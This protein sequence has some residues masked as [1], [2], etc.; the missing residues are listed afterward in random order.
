MQLYDRDYRS[1]L[2]AEHQEWQALQES[3]VVQRIAGAEIRRSRFREYPKAARHF[4]RLFPNNYLD[5][6]E[7]N[8]KE[9]L[10]ERIRGFTALL[11]SESVSERQV[12]NFIIE[13]RA[14]FI[15]G[16]L[17]HAY[18]P[19]G[20]HEAY[21]FPEFQLGN[22]FKVDHLLV[23]KNSGGW[24][25]VFVE[26][27]APTGKITLVDG[28]LGETF[29]KGLAQVGEWD[30]W[31]DARYSSISESFEKATRAGTVLPTE[32]CQ[33]DRSRIHFVVVAG[34]RKDFREA[35]YRI[36]RKQPQHLL[37]YD[38]V[39]DAARYVIGELTY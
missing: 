23:G 38:N 16:A 13:Q 11:D 35:T 15:V 31:L 27:E 8:E 20:H 1:L 17:L 28:S 5:T 21:L 10:S 22:S 24:H 29:R 37:H 33:L 26:L 18:F 25:F 7:L 12:L 39:V 9:V 2:P 34:R 4:T 36:C 19:F 6:V 30:A 14:Y 32:F 3:E